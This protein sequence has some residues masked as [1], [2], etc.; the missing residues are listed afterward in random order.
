VQ[1]VQTNSVIDTILD[2]Y[3]DALGAQASPYR[4]HV[5]RGLN[6]HLMMSGPAKSNELALAWAAHDLGLWTAR[7]MDYLAPSALLA[8]QL[9]PEFHV[10]PSHC[11]RLMIENHHCLRPLGDPLAEGFRQAD[12]AD[13][14]PQRWGKSV[15]P[16]QYAKL[17]EAFPY[18]GFHEFLGRSALRYALRHPLRP[19]PMFRFRPPS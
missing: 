4:N 11:L 9:A 7:T 6:L 10:E 5:Y 16:A 19:F 17:V 15:T 8:E 14:W 13:A 3:H 1:L 2:R 12:R 18:C